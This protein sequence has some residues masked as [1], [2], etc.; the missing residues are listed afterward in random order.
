MIAKKGIRL[1]LGVQQTTGL[2]QLV[3]QLPQIFVSEP[4]KACPRHWVVN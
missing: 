1:Y 2:G 3:W 4:L